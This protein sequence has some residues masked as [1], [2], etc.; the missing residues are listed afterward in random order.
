M[1][2]RIL[3]YE[4]EAGGV[5]EEVVKGARLTSPKTKSSS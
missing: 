3:R 5:M 2:R 4:E 1:G